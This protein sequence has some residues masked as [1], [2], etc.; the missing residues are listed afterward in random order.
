[1]KNKKLLSQISDCSYFCYGDELI[2]NLTN[3][4]KKGG[5]FEKLL[6]FYLPINDFSN[7]LLTELINMQQLKSLKIFNFINFENTNNE[8]QKIIFIK[9]LEL[10]NDHD[11]LTELIVRDLIIHRTSGRNKYLV[12]SDIVEALR[13]NCTIKKF[14]NVPDEFCKETYEILRRNIKYHNDKKLYFSSL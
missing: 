1:M 10:I 13:N 9:L 12:Y 3:Y 11:Y 7:Y 5:S 4:I 6:L 14:G 2:E 8:Y